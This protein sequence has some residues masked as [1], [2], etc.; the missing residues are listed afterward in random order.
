MK[1]ILITSTNDPQLNRDI[2]SKLSDFKL[3]GRYTYIH[4]NSQLVAKDCVVRKQESIYAKAYTGK[5]EGK[6]FKEKFDI[7][8]IID[9]TLSTDELGRYDVEKRKDM[10]VTVISNNGDASIKKTNLEELSSL[11]ESQPASSS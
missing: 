6:K 10:Y 7:I 11:L 9:P 3:S 2:K 4:E 8:H 1:R 5:K